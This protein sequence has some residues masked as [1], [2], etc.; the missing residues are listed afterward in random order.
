MTDQELLAIEERWNAATPGPWVYDGHTKR[1]HE[2]PGR[3]DI[4]EIVCGTEE[5]GIC[6]AHSRQDVPALITEIYRLRTELRGT[7]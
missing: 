3:W 4:A 6:I 1:V 2:T 5:D 7:L